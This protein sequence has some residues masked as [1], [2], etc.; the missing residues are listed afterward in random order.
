M[1]PDRPRFRKLLAASYQDQGRFTEAESELRTVLKQDSSAESLLQLGHVLLYQRREKEATDLLA[2]AAQLDGENGDAWLY[3]GLAY[4]R[5]GRA[6]EA[7]R[8]FQRGLS[9]AEQET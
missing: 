6:G 1:A 3:L 8:A 9:I 4:Q 5:T 7:R 2:H